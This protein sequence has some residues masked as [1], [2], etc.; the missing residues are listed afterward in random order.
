MLNFPSII[1]TM[2][3]MKVNQLYPQG[4]IRLERKM[5]QVVSQWE[6]KTGGQPEFCT[7]NNKMCSRGT[8]SGT[9][10]EGYGQEFYKMW[11]NEWSAVCTGEGNINVYENCQSNNICLLHKFILVY[12]YKLVVLEIRIV[13]PQQKQHFKWWLSFIPFVH[14]CLFN[15]DHINYCWNGVTICHL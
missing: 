1:P 7:G 6:E 13:Y 11:R 4:N 14:K 5:G 12:I 10:M 9:L 2:S 3:C 8:T 15:W